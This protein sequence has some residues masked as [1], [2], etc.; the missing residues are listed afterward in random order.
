[1]CAEL[2]SFLRAFDIHFNGDDPASGGAQHLDG[3]NSKQTSTHNCN[4]FTEY[5]SSKPDT[6]HNNC[7]DRGECGLI[8][9]NTKRYFHRHIARDE[10]HAA[11]GSVSSTA[12]GHKIAGRESSNTVSNSSHYSTAAVSQRFE[13][14][15][16]GPYLFI[17]GFGPMLACVIQN[18]AY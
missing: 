1:M 16:L 6:L 13:D 7:T 12:T 8:R 14:V 15:E 2:F 17:R 9:G 11:M 10:I 3:Q 4:G 5:T 18:F